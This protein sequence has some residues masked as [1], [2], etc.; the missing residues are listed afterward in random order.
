MEADNSASKIANRELQKQLNSERKKCDENDNQIKK[1]NEI[2]SKLRV[3]LKEAY[4]VQKERASDT[5]LNDLKNKYIQLDENY[6]AKCIE[7][8]QLIETIKLSEI[9]SAKKIEHFNS[10]T[11]E[12]KLMML[13][14]T[15]KRESRVAQLED[16]IN[17]FTEL[18]SQLE[19]E[20]VQEMGKNIANQ[21]IIE[22]VN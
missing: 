8:D 12:S 5:R 13:N 1:K 16:K 4:E 20:K 9:E 10:K 14:E 11:D 2:I 22:Q 6:K 17:D 21:R 7:V 18:C 15:K 19:R 3:D